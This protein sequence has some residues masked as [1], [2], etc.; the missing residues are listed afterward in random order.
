MLSIAGL[1]L[2]AFQPHVSKTNQHLP[3][4]SQLHVSHHNRPK[5]FVFT[6]PPKALFGLVTSLRKVRA[7]S[8]L[9][10]SKTPFSQ[11]KPVFSIRFLLVGVPYHSASS[12]N[13]QIFVSPQRTQFSQMA[14][15]NGHAVHPPPIEKRPLILTLGQIRV[16]FFH[17]TFQGKP[18]LSAVL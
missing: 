14:V 5:T 11:R 4:I 13:T 7:Q 3:A 12:R 15:P 2:K 18:M 6:G 16:R 8:G 9:D 1:T 17:A 10:Q